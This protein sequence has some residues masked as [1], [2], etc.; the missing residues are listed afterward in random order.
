MKPTNT[1]LYRA[2]EVEDIQGVHVYVVDAKCETV[3]PFKYEPYMETPSAYIDMHSM[4]L[5]W[6][7]EDGEIFTDI[8]RDIASDGTLLWEVELCP[9]L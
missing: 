2:Y 4:S 3:A 5:R 7:A 6:T 1:M 9:P 8:L